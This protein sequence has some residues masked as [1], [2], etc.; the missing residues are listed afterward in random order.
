MQVIKVVVNEKN[1][2]LKKPK[3]LFFYF[4][5][6]N[7]INCGTLVDGS[8]TTIWYSRDYA[9]WLEA[10]KRCLKEKEAHSLGTLPVTGHAETHF[11]RDLLIY[12]PT[13]HNHSL[14]L[15]Q[16]RALL[17]ACAGSTALLQLHP[18]GLWLEKDI[19]FIHYVSGKNISNF[20]VENVY[21]F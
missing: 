17:L 10:V 4:S 5:D 11:F 14:S 13:Q 9:S 20:V 2:K 16:P 18:C 12:N 8:W 7:L 19:A 1:L 15:Q 21:S 3:S 6:K